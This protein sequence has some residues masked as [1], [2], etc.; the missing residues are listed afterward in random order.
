MAKHKKTGGYIGKQGETQETIGKQE[1]KK[2][3]EGKIGKHKKWG[4]QG[5]T[6][7]NR[8]IYGKTCRGK[9]KNTWENIETYGDTRGNRKTGEKKAGRENMAKP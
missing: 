4:I 2:E 9:H 3:N 6:Q 5:K 7:E 8:G 1:K